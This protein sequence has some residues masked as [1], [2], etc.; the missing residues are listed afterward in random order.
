MASRLR[1]LLT[2]RP[3]MPPWPPPLPQA[4]RQ[5]R[6][7]CRTPSLSP[8]AP[9]A[10]RTSRE[11][12]ACRMRCPLRPRSGAWRIGFDSPP[13]PVDRAAWRIRAH[14]GASP[15]AA[16]PYSR[17]AQ[18]AI[19]HL[20]VAIHELWL[21]RPH[22][23]STGCLVSQS[24]GM[25]PDHAATGRLPHGR[26]NSVSTKA[27]PELSSYHPCRCCAPGRFSAPSL[28][29]SPTGRQAAEGAF[30]RF[31]PPAGS[32]GALRL[33]PPA[34]R[35]PPRRGASSRW[36]GSPR[37]RESPGSP[38][39]GRSGRS[40]WPSAAPASRC[41]DRPPGPPRCSRGPPARRDRRTRS[42]PP[43]GRRHRRQRPARRGAMCGR[44][45]DEPAPHVLRTN[46]IDAAGSVAAA[47][48]PPG[49][50]RRRSPP[51]PPRSKRHGPAGHIRRE[52]AQSNLQEALKNL[53]KRR[54]RGL[55]PATD[56]RDSA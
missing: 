14:A 45:A 55:L 23:I 19:R 15:A 46:D 52:Q 53:P 43:P 6:L 48:R 17:I 20:G 21:A 26:Y 34:R 47:G 9:R 51:T 50:S 54:T 30:G 22:R 28:P 39:A 10:F 42:R 36:H 2:V 16:P 40:R 37:C 49:G 25:A 4:P 35:T 8:R 12:A 13:P 33:T 32:D 31:R 38:P 18:A 41:W 5:S 11:A 27:A 24:V 1:C 56:A 7:R 29:H 3:G 44:D